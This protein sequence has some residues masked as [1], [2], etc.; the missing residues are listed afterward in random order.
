[1]KVR[2]LAPA[3]RELVDAIRYYEK[4][5]VG[6]GN[7]FRQEAWLAVERIRGLPHGWS[8]LGGNIRRCQL[9]RFPYGVIYEPLES[10]IVIIAV[11]HLHRRPDYWRTRRG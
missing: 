6:L 11:A 8:P 2:L 5:R 3:Q 9:R 4:E 7:E 10:E 1:M